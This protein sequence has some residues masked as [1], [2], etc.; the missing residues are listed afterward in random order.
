MPPIS[1]RRQLLTE[2]RDCQLTH[3]AFSKIKFHKACVFLFYNF[4]QNICQTERSR[5]HSLKKRKPHPLK[6]TPFQKTN[7]KHFY[8]KKDKK[9]AKGLFRVFKKASSS[10]RFRIKSPPIHFQYHHIYLAFP[11]THMGSILSVKLAFLKPSTR[12]DG[13]LFFPFFFCKNV[14]GASRFSITF[15]AITEERRRNLTF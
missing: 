2:N 9:E 10:L 11:Q 12:Q 6:T 5:G 15:C 14:C 7:R 1:I 13:F 3:Q 4:H 8:K